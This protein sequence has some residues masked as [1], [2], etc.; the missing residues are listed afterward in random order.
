MTTTVTSLSFPSDLLALIDAQRG[1]VSRSR[2]VSKLLEEVLIQKKS[3]EAS[4][5]PPSSA[6]EPTSGQEGESQ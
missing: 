6:Q 3:S 1:D 2:F 5:A 4:L